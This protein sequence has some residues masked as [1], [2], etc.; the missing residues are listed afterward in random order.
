MEPLMGWKFHHQFKEFLYHLEG[1]S[2]E[3]ASKNCTEALELFYWGGVGR[4][5]C[6]VCGTHGRANVRKLQIRR[7]P[8]PSR[9]KCYSCKKQFNVYYSTIF[10]GSR[11]PLIKWFQALLC[12]SERKSLREW[13]RLH[14][15]QLR[16]ARAMKV[17]IGKLGKS[18][19]H[20]KLY[21]IAERWYDTKIIQ[22]EN[23]ILE[24]DTHAGNQPIDI[25]DSWATPLE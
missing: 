24:D 1:L 4:A 5:R 7:S 9:Y 21:K 2:P 13:A 15:I 11:I 22:Q 8:N 3:E 20:N 25:P 10:K 14:E 19:E 17:K 16:D 12:I 6:P 18:L 23:F